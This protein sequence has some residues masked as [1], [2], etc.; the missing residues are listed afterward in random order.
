MYQLGARAIVVA[1]RVRDVEGFGEREDL[2]VRSDSFLVREEEKQ[3]N[4]TVTYK[5]FSKGIS[6]VS[7]S[8]ESRVVAVDDPITI[9]GTE[10]SAVKSHLFFPSE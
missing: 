6:T 1:G 8:A 5:V 10:I 9:D 3:H 7:S 4:L 2:M